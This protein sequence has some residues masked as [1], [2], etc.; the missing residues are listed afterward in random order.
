MATGARHFD[1]IASGYARTMAPSLRPVAAEVVRRAGLG[2]GESILD[3]G[4]GTGNAAALARGDGR[5]VRGIDAAPAML[6]IAR[7]EVPDVTFEEMD[8]TALRFDDASFDVVLAVHALLF[9]DDERAALVEWRRVT[10]PGGRLSLSVPGPTDVTPTALYAE[11]Y[12]RHGIDTSGRYPTPTSL[13]GLAQGAGW[14]AVEVAADP[15]TAIVLPDEDA[16]RVWRGIGSRGAATA[17]YTDEQH[18]ALTDEMLA[19]TPRDAD[20]S[21]RIPFGAIYLSARREDGG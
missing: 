11:I 4:T 9:A 16:F 7:A 20:G 13:A 8:F 17:H 6:E 10:R 3:I 14:S 5:Q 15:T 12:A 19:V 18:R 21:L 1:S 2:P